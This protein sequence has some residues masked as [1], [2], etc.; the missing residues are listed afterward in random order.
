[1]F[2][3]VNAFVKEN[4]INKKQIPY[5]DILVKQNHK[6][7]Y[8]Y[9]DGYNYTPSGKEILYMYSCTKPL[10]AVCAMQLL[11][12]GK[13]SLE[14]EVNKYLPEYD[15]V[16]LLDSNG[17]KVKP[18]NKMKI[19]HL[20]TMTAGLN[21]DTQSPF[22]KEV[23]KNTN[24]TATTRQMVG[25]FIKGPLAFEPGSDFLYSFC[26][27][28]MGAIIEVVTGTTLDKY[29]H[30]NVFKPLNMANSSFDKEYFNGNI[31]DCYTFNGK[32]FVFEDLY[33]LMKLSGGFIS[34][35]GGLL[36]SVED[37]SIFADALACNGV[38]ENGYK[39]LDESFIELMSSEQ[40][41]KLSVN[42]TF[43]CVQGEDYGYGF[44]VRTRKVALDCGVPVGEFGWDGAA[45]SYLLVDRKNNISITIGMNILNWPNV[46]LNEHLN[47][48]KL[49]YKQLNL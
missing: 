4:L 40:V 28:V 25:A 26:L 12:D 1:M 47:I 6:T 35:G 9:M 15:S 23:I 43:T 20:L 34:G 2:E 5:I 38:A 21:Y 49:I 10:T 11:K 33:S 44:G 18:K 19:K 8:R 22:I 42:N 36:S 48:I 29:V 17:N 41:S 16:Y 24:D 3:N 46:F 39:L 31:K 32:E 14:D 27:D 45:G 37:Y 30:N 13:I 7:I